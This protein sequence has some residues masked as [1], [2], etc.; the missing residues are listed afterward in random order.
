MN[1]GVLRLGLLLLLCSGCNERVLAS[2]DGGPSDTLEADVWPAWPAESPR[3]KVDVAVVLPA[4][5]GVVEDRD[6]LLDVFNRLT[7]RLLRPWNRA[8]VPDFRV[9]FL[10]PYVARDITCSDG[11]PTGEQRFLMPASVDDSAIPKGV[12]W[13]PKDNLV[14]VV[15][16]LSESAGAL[17]PYWGRISQADWCEI[18][19]HLEV[20]D[21]A[22]DGRNPGFPRADALLVIL[23]GGERDDCSIADV[24]K[25]QTSLHLLTQNC[26][27]PAP[28]FL[29]SPEAIV[30]AIAARHA[31]PVLLSVLGDCSE[32]TFGVDGDQSVDCVRTSNG[33]CDSGCILPTPRL[34]AIAAGF[35]RWRPNMKSLFG[36]MCRISRDRDAIAEA[37][38]EVIFDAVER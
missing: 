19:E 12:I 16:G 25:W 9:G 22:L 7:E 33:S 21:R 17:W 11:L 28:G 13:P 14:H 32:P 6:F 37:L 8:P 4:G 29:R 24:T 1:R 2:L 18:N 10:R 23:V 3:G 38:A 15:G 31:G 27:R 34:C 35:D 5:S 26:Y 30:R 20:V 36:E